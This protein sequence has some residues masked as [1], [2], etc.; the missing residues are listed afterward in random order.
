MLQRNYA[1]ISGLNNPHSLATLEVNS[2]LVRK[3][4]ELTG[5]RPLSSATTA[6]FCLMVHHAT[7]SPLQH[8][9]LHIKDFE[10]E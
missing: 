8:H 9:P 10:S 6:L 4:T 5:S 7:L 3:T 1:P 2:L